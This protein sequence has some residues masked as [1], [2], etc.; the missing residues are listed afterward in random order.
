M[1]EVT[2]NSF[3]N[4]E[5]NIGQLNAMINDIETLTLDEHDQILKIIDIENSNLKY[6]ENENGIFIKL[7]TLSIDV[8]L[9]IY[10]YVES[11]RNNKNDIETAVQ[12]L[13]SYETLNKNF[14]NNNSNNSDLNSTNI[15]IED[16]KVAIIEKMRNTSKTKG[17]KK[18]KK[19]KD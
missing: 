11:I 19:N 10:E 2:S 5:L 9:K 7:N 1:E 14:I 12:T 6:T 8:I 16:W 17:K 3:T 15:E 4:N 13:E 18:I